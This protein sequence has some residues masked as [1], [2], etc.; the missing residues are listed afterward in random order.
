MGRKGEAELTH[1]VKRP[2]KIIQLKNLILESAAWN[3]NTFSELIE[4]SALACAESW[5]RIERK[6]KIPC[7]TCPKDK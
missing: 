6:F 5:R 4:A 3:D 1:K 7:P 2:R